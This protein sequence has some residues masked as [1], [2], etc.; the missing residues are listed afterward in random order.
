MGIRLKASIISVI[1]M[2]ILTIIIAAVGSRLYYENLME[3]YIKYSEMVLETAY[4]VSDDYSFG[5]MI[6]ERSM[7]EGYEKL[8]LQ[9]NRVKDC[10][11]I[12]Y[13]YAVY[14]DDIDELHS[15]CYA[16][17]AKNEEELSGGKPVSG[18][19]S[20]MGTPC[21]D[22]SFEDDTLGILQKAVREGRQESGFLTGHSREYGYML[23]GYRVVFD[24]AGEA[25]GLICVE[26]DVNEI[27]SDI[28][29]YLKRISLIALLITV[30]LVALY[31]LRMQK[32]VIEPIE[33]ITKETDSFISEMNANTDPEN[34]KFTDLAVTTKDEMQTLAENVKS[35]ADSVSSYMINLKAATSEKERISTELSVANEI[36]S[37]ML[38]QKF[39]PYPERKEFS[40][41]ASMNTAKEVGGDFYDFFMPDDDH[42]ALV[43]A[44]VSGKGVPAAMFMAIS[45]V[46]INIRCRRD[47]SSPAAIL[48]DVNEI[49]CNDND[50]AMFVTVWLA[51]IE[52]STG[53]G[54]AANAG[55]EHPALCHKNGKFEL[56]RYRHTLAVAVMEETMFKEHEFKL[57]PG[58][59]LFVYTDGVTEATAPNAEQLGEDRLIKILNKDPNADPEKLL[60]NVNDGINE[61]VKDAEQFDDITMMNF[62]YRGPENTNKN[63]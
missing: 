56:V 8:R 50:A 47:F 21:E 40:I 43:M 6:K 57:E 12:K 39:P 27:N 49:L 44:D 18:I 35:M 38:P 30:V 1:F 23:N 16:I 33:R 63:S 3:N 46:L 19:Y 4:R 55:H 7:P 13:L 24:S 34:L 36:Q 31:N 22:G 60:S 11:D 15:L 25:V 53:K 51:I 59:S 10:A 62:Y 41:Y 9:L 26:I 37:S 61:F 28:S 2:A 58:D 45:K 52:I 42:I 14:F 54:I 32:Q 29:D 20:Y 5:D 48:S 17:N